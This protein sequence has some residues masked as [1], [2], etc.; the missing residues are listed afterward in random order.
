MVSRIDARTFRTAI[1]AFALC[2]VAS[3][4]FAHPGGRASDGCHYCRS[5]C[6]KWNLEK[7]ERHCH[8]EGSNSSA[9]N[10]APP[11]RVACERGSGETWRGLVVAPECRCTPYDR[12]DYPYPQS[13]EPLIAQR[14]GMTSKYSGAVFR[15]LKESDIE[16]VV[17]LSEAHDSGLCAASAAVRRAFARDLDNLALATPRLNRHQKSGHDAAEWLPP[18]N[19]CWY[20][21]T[22]IAV[23]QEYRLTIDRHEVKALERVLADCRPS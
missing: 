7:D 3:V 15:S 13:V 22:I 23:R 14:D 6:E 17:S 19:R 21:L 11:Q 20:A 16:H 9:S 5:N 12:D 4:G 1:L 2:F 8:D 18:L 10:A